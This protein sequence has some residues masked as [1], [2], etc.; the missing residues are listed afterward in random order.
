[1]IVKWIWL[2]MDT[3]GN[4]HALPD[5]PTGARLELGFF[6]LQ[7]E[8]VSLSKSKKKSNGMLLELVFKDI[9]F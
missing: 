8:Q 3:Q 4:I 6:K 9:I 2:F 7:Y 1:M 5:L